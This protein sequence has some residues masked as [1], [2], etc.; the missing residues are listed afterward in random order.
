MLGLSFDTLTRVLWTEENIS[1]Q[2]DEDAHHN[3][4]NKLMLRVQ[5]SIRRR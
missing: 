2:M 5:P 1:G 4:D 3:P